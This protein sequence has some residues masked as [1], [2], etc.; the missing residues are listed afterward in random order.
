MADF[1]T[2]CKEYRDYMENTSIKTGFYTRNRPNLD[3]L[4]T[5]CN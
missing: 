1:I 2:Y 4:F 5:F 3:D